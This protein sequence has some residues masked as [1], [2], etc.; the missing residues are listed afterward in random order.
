MTFFEDA[1]YKSGE[2]FTMCTYRRRRIILPRI[3]GSDRQV[4][5]DGSG[6]TYAMPDAKST[7]C[8]HFIKFSLEFG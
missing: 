1:R 7:G 2:Y 3:D 8:I 6:K 4:F 5:D